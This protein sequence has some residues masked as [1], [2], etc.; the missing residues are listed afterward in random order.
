MEDSAL[1]AMSSGAGAPNPLTTL[2]ASRRVAFGNL[3]PA[4]VALVSEALAK[5]EVGL[6]GYS[7]TFSSSS[8]LA[9][10]FQVAPEH[11]VLRDSSLTSPPILR[12]HLR[13]AIELALWLQLCA[14]QLDEVGSLSIAILA[15]L[16]TTR[17]YLQMLTAERRRIAAQVPRWLQEAAAAAE[18]GRLS[19]L[20]A[21]L[22]V[23]APLHGAHLH[24]SS[25]TQAALQR[26]TQYSALAAPTEYILTQQGDERLLLD[27]ATGL[28]KYG[29]SPRPRPEAITFSSCTAS[30]VSEFAYRAAELLRH[31]LMQTLPRTDLEV[32]H[33]L[34]IDELRATLADLLHLDPQTEV[35]LS[36]SGTDAELYPLALL[37]ST[38]KPR[39]INIVVAPDEVGGGT[40]HAAAGCHFGTRTPLGASV[41]QGQ[42]ITELDAVEVIRIP[43]RGSDGAALSDHDLK[44]SIRDAT[45][46][47]VQRADRVIL[48]L[49]DNS[50]TGV[51][52]PDFDFAL[53]LREAVGSKLTVLVDACQF[54]LERDNL[55]RY[56]AHGFWVLITGSKF[57]TGPPFGG[58]LL[59]PNFNAAGGGQP[60]P[61][62]FA[63]YFTR[64]EV[65]AG[66]RNRAGALSPVLNLG[67]LL[68][69]TGAI[70]E[71]NAFYT[72][73]SERRTEILQTF[74]RQL[75][76]SIRNTPELR[77]LDCPVPARSADAD[78]T[79]WDAQPTIFSFAVRGPRPEPADKMMSLSDLKTLYYLLNHDCAAQL[80]AS[81]TDAER[82]LA[83][84]KCHIGQ[85]VTIGRS[86]RNG[87][88]CALRMACGARLV[89]GITY[90]EGL[91]KTPAERFQRELTDAQ[92]VLKKIVLLLKYWD[93]L[94]HDVGFNERACIPVE[95]S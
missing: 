70:A 95:I 36:S 80:P 91:G 86:A 73:P 13:H 28:N 60:F 6:C 9:T 32:Q 29:C 23:L 48:H 72:V 22:P 61:S 7:T 51:I 69:W 94:S 35:I 88:T 55:R 45:A 4:H 74:R 84:Q 81:A 63:N 18:E 44:Q 87:D 1:T 24:G 71:M 14:G 56:L 64:S 10:D 79:L 76:D 43:I 40:A 47:A 26:A 65:P 21:Q 11:V 78:E 20:A 3:T 38:D 31:R 42:P 25:P 92:S 37:R 77:L 15:A 82:Q 34:E 41:R 83:A 39:L 75:V 49:V 67:L 16:T 59:I 17:F 33:Q 12:L 62:G 93:F 8:Q 66:L 53:A 90:D 85:P 57:F 46:D 30:S 5:A 89:Y 50:K 58:A 52:A 54:R 68:R 2:A 27:P 19:A